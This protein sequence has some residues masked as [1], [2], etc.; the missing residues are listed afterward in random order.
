ME[1]KL[2]VVFELL[3]QVVLEVVVGVQVCYFVFVFVGYQFEQVVCYGFGQ[4]SGIVD[5]VGFGGVYVCYQVMVVFGVGG[6]LVFDQE[7]GVVFD[8]FIQ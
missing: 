3:L 4:C 1:V 8:Y 7:C 2:V 5:V 6:I